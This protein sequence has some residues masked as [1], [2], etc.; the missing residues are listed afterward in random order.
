MYRQMTTNNNNLEEI[1]KEPSEDSNMI[2]KKMDKEL[3]RV[4]SDAFGKVKERKNNGGCK[5]LDKLQKVKNELL[6]RNVSDKEIKVVDDKISEMLSKKQREG[7][8]KELKSIRDLKSCNGKFA[9]IFDLKGKIVGTKSS[10][11]EATVLID[12]KSGDE[13]STQEEI[14]CVSLEYCSTDK[15][16]A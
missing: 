13:V 10:G 1:A 6:S 9:A 2:M 11:Q 5:E 7:F 15:Q 4:K 8:K 12:S 16:E 14:K 3:N